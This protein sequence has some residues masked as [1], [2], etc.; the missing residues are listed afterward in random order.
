MTRAPRSGRWSGRGVLSCPRKRVVGDLLPAVL[1]DGKVG[2]P[3]ELLVVCYGLGVAVVLHVRLVDSGRH[4][5]VL[6]PRYEEQGR[7]VLVPEV[8]VGVLVTGREVG[9]GPGP[10]EAARRRDV[11]ALVDLVRLLAAQSVGEGVVELLFGEANR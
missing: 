4:E 2:A 1:P 3:R 6:A 11:V 9:E 5:V 7:P 8:H 10:H